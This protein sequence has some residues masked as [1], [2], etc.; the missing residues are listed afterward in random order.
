MTVAEAAMPVSL[1]EM[2]LKITRYLNILG[3]NTALTHHSKNRHGVKKL[4][5]KFI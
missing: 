1:M 2:L 4:R 5:A 3:K